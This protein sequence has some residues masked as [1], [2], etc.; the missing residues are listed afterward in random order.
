MVKYE[1]AKLFHRRQT[2]FFV[3]LLCLVNVL[4]L[5]RLPLPGVSAYGDYSV[6]D[7]RSVYA[8]LPRE[9]QAAAEAIPRA[10]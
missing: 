3:L 10:P 1:I 2:R 8:A 9:P 4:V 6:T 5:F 7:V